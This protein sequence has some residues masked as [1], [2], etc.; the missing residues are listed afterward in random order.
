MTFAPS[1]PLDAK[2][3]TAV[4]AHQRRDKGFGPALGPKA[5]GAAVAQFEALGYDVKQAT[6]DWMFG[7]LDQEIQREVLSGWA[8]AT[9]EVG[10]VPLNEAV[11]WLTRRRD[12]V[13]A[14]TSSIRVGHVDFFAAPGVR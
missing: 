14:G 4:N 12:F 1:D 9:R 3:V 6:S 10:D 7:P 2:I 5:A 11:E 8:T 13:A